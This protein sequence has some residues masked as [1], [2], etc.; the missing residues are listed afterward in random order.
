MLCGGFIW[1]ITTQFIIIG[2]NM[3]IE[4]K[5]M[6]DFLDKAS[7][8]DETEGGKLIFNKDLLTITTV[9]FDQT[10]FFEG[11]IKKDVISGYKDGKVYC[12]ADIRMLINMLKRMGKDTDITIDENN[13]IILQS[14][15]KK[16]MSKIA[17]KDLIADPPETN[18]EYDFK[19][20]IKTAE[21]KDVLKDV[22]A[23][24]ATAKGDSVIKM[25]VTGNKIKFKIDE[26]D[27]VIENEIIMDNKVEVDMT[28]AFS[29]RLLG[30]AIN[31][32][33]AE[34][35][36]LHMKSD[37]PIKIEENLGNYNINKWYVA[38]RDVDE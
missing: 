19:T 1:F 2:V 27:N 36:T 26:N 28:I 22:S 14:G 12:I 29:A 6:I 17:D 15:K 31:C 3:K 24:F 34:Y 38:P 16:I 37:Y 23:I 7:L 11:G 32:L 25:L 10:T 5:K 18:L 33:T 13:T 9:A 35:V 30:R 21:I 8:S 4:T 20:K